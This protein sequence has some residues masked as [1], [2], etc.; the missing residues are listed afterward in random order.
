MKILEDA[1][2]S[3]WTPWTKLYEEYIDQGGT[4]HCADL[5]TYR[6][7]LGYKSYLKIKNLKDNFSSVLLKMINDFH[8]PTGKDGHAILEKLSMKNSTKYSALKIEKYM[9]DSFEFLEKH[10]VALQSVTARDIAKAIVQGLQPD[11]FQIW[12]GKSKP[13]HLDAVIEVIRQK[14]QK[15]DE[16]Y[17]IDGWINYVE[18]TAPQHIQQNSNKNKDTAR[19][20]INKH[21]DGVP[22]NSSISNPPNNPSPKCFNCGGPHKIWECQI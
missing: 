8:Q 11:W 20:K 18:K 10:E 9:F 4:K 15:M 21:T 13:Q 14:M 7:K 19:L 17:E 22:T 5:W 6:D 1:K 16:Y 2:E 12:V 3:S